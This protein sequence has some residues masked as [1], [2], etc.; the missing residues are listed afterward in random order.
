MCFF[1]RGPVRILFFIPPEMRVVDAF[2]VVFANSPQ[3][4]CWGG[5]TRYLSKG[6]LESCTLEV[7]ILS[8]VLRSYQTT[9]SLVRV[10]ESYPTLPKLGGRCWQ[11]IPRWY[12]TLYPSIAENTY[13]IGSSSRS[14]PT[15]PEIWV[16]YCGHTQLF[17]VF[18]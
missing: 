4:V 8:G 16:E 5:Y 13:P 11:V 17:P 18:G 3:K 12:C 10:L 15:L 14:Y 9:Q 1:F 7:T 6:V 2:H